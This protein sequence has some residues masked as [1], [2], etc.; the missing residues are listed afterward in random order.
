MKIMNSHKMSQKIVIKLANQLTTTPLY[1]LTNR[2]KHSPDRK[3]KE[4]I[5]IKIY[6]KSSGG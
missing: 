6:N 3:L 1:L 4:R 5:R 2:I